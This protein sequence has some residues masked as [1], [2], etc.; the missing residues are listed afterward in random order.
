MCPS[1]ATIMCSS[2]A[3]IMCL[4]L[5][6]IMRVSRAAIQGSAIQG[7]FNTPWP[8]AIPN[9]TESAVQDTMKMENS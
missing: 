6:T 9:D 8:N 1:L 2:L 4:W 3:T 5:A 7:S